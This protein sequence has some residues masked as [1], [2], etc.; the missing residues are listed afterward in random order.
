MVDLPLTFSKLLNVH[1]QAL[2]KK[3]ALQVVEAFFCAVVN[4]VVCFSFK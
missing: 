2:N 3:N 4:T 1:V